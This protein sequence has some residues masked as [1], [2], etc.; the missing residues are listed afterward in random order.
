MT[1]E[2][3]E[4]AKNK[5]ASKQALFSDSN[6]VSCLLEHDELLTPKRVF[7]KKI[8]DICTNVLTNQIYFYYKETGNTCQ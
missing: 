8:I 3:I 6:L 4:L 1:C 5:Q 7:S 2:A